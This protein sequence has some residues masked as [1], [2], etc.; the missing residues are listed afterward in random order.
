MTNNLIIAHRGESFD[1]PENTL[2]AINL[3]WKRG[4][5]AVE[6]DIRLTGD[7]EIVVIHDND[8]LRI[9]GEKKIIKNTTLK[10]LK[11]LNAGFHKGSS[12]HNV[13]IPTLNEVLATVPDD[14]RLIIE[15]KSN[16]SILPKLL[17][18]LSKSK[19]NDKQIEI[20]AFNEDTLAKAKQLMPQYNMLWLLNLDYSLPK[21]LISNN[22]KK[23][24][25]KVNELNLDGVNVW[26]GEMLTQSFILEYK[27]ASLLIYSW[28]VDNSEKAIELFK[29]GID[30]VTTNKAG[31]MKQQMPKY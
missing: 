23:T 2:A 16:D 21:W 7:N 22:N 3:A 4:A 31:W 30:G 27:K 25:N 9:A 17:S 15:I 19:L 26:A 12:W 6:I 11:L 1:A 18:E 8:T 20:I 28:T 24:I 13:Q 29:N 10:E 14:G 5:K